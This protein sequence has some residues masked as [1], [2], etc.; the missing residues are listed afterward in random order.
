MEEVRKRLQKILTRGKKNRRRLISLLQ[1]VQQEFGYL[2]QEAMLR[3]ARFLGVPPSTVYGVAT[4]Y[5]QFRFT[6]VGKHPM[7]VCL[8]T[9]CHLAGGKLVLEMVERELD[10]KVGSVTTDG[11]FGLERVACI[12][13]CALAP[14]M[15]INSDVYP[16]LTPVKTEEVLTLIKSRGESEGK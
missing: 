3:I 16:K 2:P 14:V 6:P 4:F 10:I 5:N 11:R 13:C 15:T 7:R 8:G 12:G 9:A 1:E